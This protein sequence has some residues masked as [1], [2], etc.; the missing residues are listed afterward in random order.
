MSNLTG[1]LEGLVGA[2]MSMPGFRVY[3]EP[4]P[5]VEWHHPEQARRAVDALKSLGFVEAGRF[6]PEGSADIRLVGLVNE[7]QSLMAAVYDQSIGG[8]RIDVVFS[9]RDGN[10]WTVTNVPDNGLDRQA[11]DM[12]VRLPEAGAGEL[13]EAAL[14]QQHGAAV[15]PVTRDGFVESFEDAYAR[16]MDWR[17][18]RGGY[19]LEEIRRVVRAKGDALPEEL[20]EQFHAAFNAKLCEGVE[21]VLYD[22]LLETIAPKMPDWEQIEGDLAFIYDMLSPQEVVESLEPAASQGAGN[23]N[24]IDGE[25]DRFEHDVDA[26]GTE[27]D[28]PWREEVMEDVRATSARRAFAKALRDLPGGMRVRKLATLE[29]PVA[30]DVYVM[31]PQGDE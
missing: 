29:R 27:D 11:S 4:A 12:K 21:E 16:E 22:E 8:V 24:V 2:V 6:T 13:V 10:H 1:Q 20:I 25:E 18:N 9:T 14:K 5:D 15:L 23:E 26:D 31:P 3:L 19:T 17:V 30:A 7:R 28:E